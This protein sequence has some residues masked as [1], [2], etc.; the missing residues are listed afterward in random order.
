VPAISGKV[1]NINLK[2]VVIAISF[3]TISDMCLIEIVSHTIAIIIGDITKVD[4]R[5]FRKI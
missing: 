1:H 2:N 4:E 3:E 5:S